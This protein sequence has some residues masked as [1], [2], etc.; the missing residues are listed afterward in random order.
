[1]RALDLYCGAG[2]A[3]RGLQQAGFYVTGVYLMPMPRYCGEVFVQMV[4]RNIV[5]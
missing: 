3:T 1:M 2:G 4:G 5:S